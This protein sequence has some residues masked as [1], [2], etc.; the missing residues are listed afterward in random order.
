MRDKELTASEKARETALHELRHLEGLVE[1]S[2][3]AVLS[4]ELEV[5]M[6]EMY[7]KSEEGSASWVGCGPDGTRWLRVQVS[8]A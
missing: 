1:L 5:G 3:V 8:D 4:V 2:D 7:V 6:R